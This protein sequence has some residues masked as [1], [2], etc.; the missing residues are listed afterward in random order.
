VLWALVAC[1]V[2]SNEMLPACSPMRP[3]LEPAQARSTSRS[4]GY[5][6]AASVIEV[7]RRSRLAVR[8][9]RATPL[10]HSANLGVD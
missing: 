9:R 2:V 5:H 3:A 6:A 8:S 4:M 1:E 10:C 7:V